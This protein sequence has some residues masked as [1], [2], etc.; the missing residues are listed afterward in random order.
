[1]QKHVESFREVKATV[2][3]EDQKI[4]VILPFFS[5][6]LARRKKEEARAKS[7]K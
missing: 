2:L 6:D 7:S 5:Q 1:M 3:C 4:G